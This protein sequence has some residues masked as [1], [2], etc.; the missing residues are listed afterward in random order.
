[1]GMLRNGSTLVGNLQNLTEFDFD[2][3][4]EGF[5]WLVRDGQ[6]YVSQSNDFSKDHKSDFVM[7]KAARTALGLMKDGSIFLAAVD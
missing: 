6:S 1:M 7:V 2:Y 5:G 4:I 3:L